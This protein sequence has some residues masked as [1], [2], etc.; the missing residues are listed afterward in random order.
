MTL[1]WDVRPAA[2]ASAGSPAAPA[3]AVG[4]LTVAAATSA[5]ALAWDSFVASQRNATGYHAWAWRGVFERAFGH[6]TIYL[7]AR[8]EASIRGVLPLVQINSRLFGRTL[9]SLPFLNYGGVLGEDQTAAAALVDAAADIARSTRCRHVE[10]RHRHRRFAHLPDKQ[11]KVTMLL[12]LE[13]A[14]WERL[15]KKVRNQIRKAQKSGLTV[16]RGGVE[17]LPDFYAVFARNMRDLGT[18]VYGR[19]FFEEILRTFPVQAHLHVVRLASLPVAAGLTYQSGET[20]EIPWASST[21]AHNHLCPNHMLYWSVIE[22]ATAIG[23]RVFDFGRSTPDEGTYKFKEQW[24]AAPLPL[25][26]E[27]A[28]VSAREMPDASPANPKYAAAIAAWQRLPLP[29]ANALGPLIVRSIP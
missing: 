29:L 20:L 13:H 6:Q 3:D 16:E 17:L 23:C 12:P 27:Y 11:H 1:A 18:P 2:D 19:I 9:T 25:H 7:V 26:W 10:L 22:Y 5:D 14:G 8:R 15:D 28:L 21:R 24:G 4:P